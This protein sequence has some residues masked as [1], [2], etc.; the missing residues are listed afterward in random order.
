MRRQAPV[1]Q[2]FLLFWSWSVEIL[3]GREEQDVADGGLI[4]QEHDQT[5]YAHTETACWRQ[6]V[7][8]C[9]DEVVV[10]VGG[11]L[12]AL[13]LELK[14]MLET[15][16]LIDRV[17]ELREG[18][19]KLAAGDEQL[20]ALGVARVRSVLFGQRGDLHRMAGQEGRLNQLVLDKFVEEQ[21]EDIALQMR[22]SYSMWCSL[23][24]RS[25]F[26]QGVDLVEVDAGV[27]S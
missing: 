19:G 25:G 27:T 21:V 10:H 4:G 18:V 26:L 5:V 2:F 6:A 7:F 20:E 17:V 9:G 15:L 11:F 8:Q 22:C 16:L 13:C 1:R 14:L 23:A 3:H 12:V 24:D